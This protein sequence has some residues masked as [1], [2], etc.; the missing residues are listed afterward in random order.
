MGDHVYPP[1]TLP[2]QHFLPAGKASFWKAY[3]LAVPGEHSGPHF[4]PF[5]RIDLLSKRTADCAERGSKCL[6][7]TT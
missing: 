4:V 7:T 5:E 1:E 2:S 3:L 6:V